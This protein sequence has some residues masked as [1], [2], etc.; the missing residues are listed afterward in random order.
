VHLAL[1]IAAERATNCIDIRV[2]AAA[3][4]HQAPWFE[5]NHAERAGVQVRVAQAEFLRRDQVK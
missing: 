5:R 4:A 2:A 3:A 1:G